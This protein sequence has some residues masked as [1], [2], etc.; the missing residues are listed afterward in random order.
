MVPTP[1]VPVIDSMYSFQLRAAD[2]SIAWKTFGDGGESS[3]VRPL[4][5][6]R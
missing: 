4:V 1:Q 2:A 6:A 3:E 5:I